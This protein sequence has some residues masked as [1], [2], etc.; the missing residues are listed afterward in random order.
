MAHAEDGKHQPQNRKK[1][2]RRLAAKLIP[3]M[4]AA[5]QQEVD[6]QELVR[7]RTYHE[8]RNTVTDHRTGQQFRFRPFRV[9]DHLDEVWVQSSRS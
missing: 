6:V 4:K 5:A 7:I 2:F 8:P 9:G 1:A 3:L